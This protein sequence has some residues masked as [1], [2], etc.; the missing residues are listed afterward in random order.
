[1]QIESSFSLI[2]E[3]APIFL[4][5]DTLEGF[6]LEANSFPTKELAFELKLHNTEVEKIILTSNEDEE[7]E[8][9]TMD[10]GLK[11]RSW[12]SPMSLVGLQKRSSFLGGN[13]SRKE[14]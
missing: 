12:T 2:K 7:G 11:R 13:P 8:L 14:K 3:Q 6:E 1:M 5:E 4:Q 9:S 10:E